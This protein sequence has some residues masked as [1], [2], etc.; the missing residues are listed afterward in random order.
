MVSR[1]IVIRKAGR[2]HGIIIV[3]KEAERERPKSGARYGLHK[4][5]L[6]KLFWN[7]KAPPKGFIVSPKQC[8][9]LGHRYSNHEPVGSL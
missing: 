6:S 1:E 2:V 8:Y 7:V 4:F 3:D 9:Q 5:T